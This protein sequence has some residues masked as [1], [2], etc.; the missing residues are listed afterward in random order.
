LRTAVPAE[1]LLVIYFGYVAA[2]RAAFPAAAHI[3]WRPFLVECWLRL[4]SGA[5]LRRVARASSVQHDARD[6]VPVALLLVAYREMDWFSRCRAISIW[7]CAGCNGTGRFFIM[8]IA[9]RDRSAGRARAAFIWSFATLLVYAVG[10]P[11]G[12]SSISSTGASA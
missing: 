10:L 2:D 7:N 9:A 4:V 1:W 11:G 6:W 8:G 5:G 3:V 12:D